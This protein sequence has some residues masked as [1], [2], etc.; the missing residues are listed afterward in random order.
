MRNQ[1][2]PTFWDKKLKNEKPFP[3]SKDRENIV[4]SFAR[5]CPGNY[6]GIGFGNA[7]LEKRLLRS[8][9]LNIF[10]IDVSPYSVSKAKR[11]ISGTFKKANILKIPFKNETF[12]V[13]VALEILEHIPAEKAHKALAEINRVLKEN[14]LFVVSVPLNEGLMEMLKAGVNPNAHMREYTA[15]LLKSELKATGFKVTKRRFLYA[16]ESFYFLKKLLQK[17]VFKKHWQPNNIII[18]AKK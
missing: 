16:F 7:N 10:G 12:D 14:G 4:F 1:N 13:V 9:P 18:F 15:K 17:C 5:Q 3:M 6:L 2:T 8:S 11:Q